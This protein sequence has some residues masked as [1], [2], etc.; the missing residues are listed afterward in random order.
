MLHEEELI[1]VLKETMVK[2]DIP[3]LAI[4]IVQGNEI[5]FGQTYG[6]QSTATGV[7]IGLDSVFC[8]ASVSKCFVATAVMQMVERGQVELDAA[9]SEYLPYFRLDDHRFTQITIRQ[10]LSHTAG[11]PD[12]SEFEY[13]ELLAHPEADEGSAER[14]V[15]SLGNRKL[16]ARPGA[17][18]SYSNIGYNVL[19]DLL[20]KVSG[21]PFETLMQESVMLPSGMPHSTFL[22]AEVL[23]DR[24][25]V[26]HLFSPKVLPNPVYPYHRADAPASF[27][28]ST[29]VDMCHWAMTSLSRGTFAGRSI[30]S[31]AAYTQMWAPVASWGPPFP[32]IYEDM[33]LG[34]TL[35]HYKGIETVSHGGMGFGWIDFLLML[36]EKNSAVVMMCNGESPVRN[37]IV[38]AAADVLI[39][40]RPEL[41]PVSWMVPISRALAD[42]GIAAALACSEEIN[43][44]PDAGFYVDPHD[45]N[46][47][48]FQ[49][50]SAGRLDLASGVLDLTLRFFPEHVDSYLMGA[51][52]QV[53][54][55]HAAGAEHSLEVAMRID[56]GNT[57]VLQALERIHSGTSRG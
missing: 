43:Q 57:C 35:G 27:L 45:L 13:H 54:Q 48:A 38:R 51:E 32:S 23:R 17:R 34:W 4:A 49:L 46:S 33:A 9:V 21:K 50:F 5:V 56:P 29:V 3:G 36:P 55:G 41:E 8:I 2:W 37:R 18:F 16:V 47:L 1:G 15:R 28:H 31:P 22:L 52:L 24:L 39:G 6:V 10:V 53:R 44:R 12:I 26:P 42:G 19:G 25:A 14:Y 20:A 40:E 11:L 7:P 30:L